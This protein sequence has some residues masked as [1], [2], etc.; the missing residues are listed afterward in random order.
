MSLEVG[1][2]VAKQKIEILCGGGTE[3]SLNTLESL[4]L[5]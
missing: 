4:I 1:V 2:N 3:G 5:F